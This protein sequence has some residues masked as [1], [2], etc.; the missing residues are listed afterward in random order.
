MILRA[1]LQGSSQLHSGWIYRKAFLRAGAYPIADGGA[2][3]R[4]HQ[5]LSWPPLSK[6]SLGPDGIMV[7]KERTHHRALRSWVS[8]AVP[9]RSGLLVL[10]DKIIQSLHRGSR[11]TTVN[12]DAGLTLSWVSP[13]VESWC[14][15]STV[16]QL[17]LLLPYVPQHNKGLQGPLLPSPALQKQLLLLLYLEK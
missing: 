11:S 10:H 17:P 1:A 16:N 6:F 13:Q 2:T 12:K 5:G 14:P 8:G 4:V 15:G 3:P 7:Q 9:Q